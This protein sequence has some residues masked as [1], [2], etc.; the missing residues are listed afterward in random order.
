MN[1]LL[2]VNKDKQIYKICDDFINIRI[3][4]SFVESNRTKKNM[5]TK[6]WDDFND[7]VVQNSIN[8]FRTLFIGTIPQVVSDTNVLFLTSNNNTKIIGNSKLFEFESAFNSKF[9][10]NY[11][12]IFISNSD[13]TEFMKTYDKNKKFEMMDDSEYINDN[14][15]SVSL[16]K[17]IFGN[18]N[19]NIK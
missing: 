12:F 10:K 13:W 9:G 7:Y 16:A 4:N 11:K 14:G 1:D 8:E 19:I 17:D 2:E 18:E 6:L 5:F 3:N 15:N